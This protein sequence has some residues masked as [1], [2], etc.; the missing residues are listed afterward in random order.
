MDNKTCMLERFSNFSIGLTLILV[1]VLFGII[2]LVIMPV[3]GLLIA[4]P[5][6]AL[7]V[8]F[9]GAGRSKACSMI[10]EKTRKLATF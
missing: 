2:S 3:V 10:T 5:V 8:A 1:G 9:L 7:G 6:I 4:F